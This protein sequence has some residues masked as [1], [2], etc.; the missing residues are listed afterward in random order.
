MTEIIVLSIIFVSF[1]SIHWQGAENELGQ[2]PC[3]MGHFG[4]KM[5]CHGFGVFGPAGG[6]FGM[7]FLLC[8]CAAAQ[9]HWA[10]V[11]VCGS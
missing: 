11:F 4:R 8:R 6:G 9:F 10:L 5:I 1:R 7:C 2:G 3:E